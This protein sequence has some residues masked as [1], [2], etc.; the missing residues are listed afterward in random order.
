M[1]L[2]NAHPYVKT[3]HHFQDDIEQIIADGKSY[4]NHLIPD[5]SDVHFLDITSGSVLTEAKKLNLLSESTYKNILLLQSEEVKKFRSKTT[6]A[7]EFE[8]N[9]GV[10]SASTYWSGP[11]LPGKICSFMNRFF[12]IWDLSEKITDRAKSEEVNG[13]QELGGEGWHCHCRTC[14]VGNNMEA[15][16]RHMNESDWLY[17]ADLSKCLISEKFE[18]QSG[19]SST[20]LEQ[21]TDKTSLCLNYAMVSAQRALQSLK[22]IPVAARRSLPV[23]VNTEGH[24]LSIPVC[25]PFYY[26]LNDKSI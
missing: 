14:A 7:I 4:V 19:L 24:L 26:L 11:L 9:H 21:T 2:F 23:I 12:L 5:A 8:S 18:Q 6:E 15:W 3:K 20:S 16:L 17:L 25:L 10:K 13:E 1:E 22:S